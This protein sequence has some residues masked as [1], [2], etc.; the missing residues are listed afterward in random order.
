MSYHVLVKTPFPDDDQFV[1]NY[2]LGAKYTWIQLYD[3][4]YN[5]SKAMQ[6]KVQVQLYPTVSRHWDVNVLH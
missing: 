3:Y 6:C 1:E 4:F 2:D 5:F